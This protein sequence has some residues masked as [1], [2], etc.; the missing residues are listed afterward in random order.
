MPVICELEVGILQ[1]AVPDEYRDRF[2]RLLR[3]A[4]IRPLEMATSRE[5]GL[6][7]RELRAKGRS[8][9]Q[10]DLILA[11]MARQYH[12]RLLTSDR[13]FEALPDIAAEN[14]IRA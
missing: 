6:V 7:Y 9:S 3:Y 4:K 13:D 2:R 1:T 11:S 14:W 12:L 8:L 5:Y 10:A